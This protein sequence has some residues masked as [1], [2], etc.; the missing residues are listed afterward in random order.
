MKIRR[1]ISLTIFLSFIM[2]AYTGIMLFLCPQGRVAYWTG[3]RLFGLS[4][5]QYGE[6]HTTFMI[7][8]LVGGIWHITLN[9]RPIK[10]YLK[11]R[12]RELKIF[13]SR[14]ALKSPEVKLPPID[15]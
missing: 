2:M 3:W 12:S 8:F 10:G 5:E 14:D 7:V 6:L 13:T 9:W 4:K 1:I 11:N 15:R